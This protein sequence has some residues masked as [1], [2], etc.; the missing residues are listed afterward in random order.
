MPWK[1]FTEDGR[2]CVH[3]I[4]PDGSMG[5]Q[6][7]CHD[8]EAQAEAQVKA[9]Y[10]NNPEARSVTWDDEK[11]EARSVAFTDIETDSD[12]GGFTG[13]AAVF[14]QTTDLGD[15]TESISRGA[16]RKAIGSS[17]NIPMLYDHNPML[18]VLATT[19]GGTLKLTEDTRG[20][21][22]EADVANHYM[23]E[24]VRELV[25]RGDIRGMSFGFVAGKG[26]SRMEMRGVKPHRDLIGFKKL[27]DVSPTWDPAYQG[28][29]AAFRS[30]RMLQIADDM[31]SMQQ[32]LKGAHP[33]L[34]DGASEP[35]GATESTETD[36]ASA[37]SD[38]QRSGVDAI[39]ARAAARKRRLQAMGL[40]LPSDLR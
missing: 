19:G 20:L 22:V 6:V 8:T 36:A 24:A 15:F 26:N 28:T 16:F 40:T 10:A 9:L 4:N 21:K 1:V 35:E 7:A 14:D 3:K 34:E 17:G 5:T 27:L 18:P 38:E 29:D 30:L 2:F 11:V 12:G 37:E 13:Y 25:K 32:L 33:Q 23:G 31:E 39:N